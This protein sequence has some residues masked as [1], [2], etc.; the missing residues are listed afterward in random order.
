M[1]SVIMD[2]RI[3]VMKIVIM[4]NQIEGQIPTMTTL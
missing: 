1:K 3:T 2:N 4:D